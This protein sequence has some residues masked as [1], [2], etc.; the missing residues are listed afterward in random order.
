MNFYSLI[1][2]VCFSFTLFTWVKCG[3]NKPDSPPAI[4]TPLLDLA[5]DTAQTRTGYGRSLK[6]TY[7]DMTSFS[8]YAESFERK[9]YLGNTWLD[10]KN[11]FPDFESPA[12]QNRQLDSIVFFGKLVAN[13]PLMLQ[14]KLEDIFHN[15]AT[16]QTLVQP[17]QQWQR[18]AFALDDFTGNFDP[19]HAKFIGFVF[20]DGLGQ[21]AGTSGSF[22]LDDLYFVESCFQKPTFAHEADMFDYLNEVAFRHFWMAVEPNSKFALDRHVWDDLISVDVIGFSLSACVIAHKEGWVEPAKVEDRVEHVLT[23][24][25]DSCAHATAP[26]MVASQPLDF[27]T[28]RGVW[29]HFLDHQTLA[30]KDKRTEFSLFTTALLLAGVVTAGEYFHWNPNIVAKADALYRMT[31]W[32]FLLRQDGL[33]NYDWKPETGFSPY[34]SDWFSEEPDLAFLLG[35]SSPEPA[36]KLP[37]NPFFLAGYRKPLCFDGTYIYSASGSN[38]TYWFLQM[39]ARYG[40]A[41]GRFQ[42]AKKA[43]L[44]DLAFCQ[45]EYAALGYDP[46]IFGT[47]A[48][49][50]TDSAG[51]AI[52]GT[53]TV[54]ISNYHA[55][56]YCCKFDPFNDGNGTVAPYGSGSAALFLPQQV[57]ALWSYFYNDLDQ[58]FWNEYASRF[59][60]PI[61]GMP[62]AFHL[63]P[64]AASDS[65]VNGLGFRGPWLSVPRFGIDVGPMLMNLDSYLSEAAGEPSVRDYFSGC[66]HIAANLAQFAEIP[67]TG[68]LSPSISI[69]AQASSVCEG[70]AIGLTATAENGGEAPVFQWF[71]N[72]VL[73]QRGND[74]TFLLQ[75]TAGSYLIFCSMI[76]SASCIEGAAAASNVDADGV[77]PAR[78]LVGIQQPRVCG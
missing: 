54:F 43:L 23:W 60:S 37:E 75:K 64:D 46:L 29:A 70:G 8:I 78:S 77:V 45:N 59:W 62:D 42:N 61:F 10:L 73:A 2:S 31:D 56:G 1:L 63:D 3:G 14:L 16:I 4:V 27:A 36:H 11:L 24:L 35:I 51:V 44:A 6:I 28:V 52:E 66:P 17:S 71:V 32:N 13:Q 76:S 9:W 50:G 5:Y 34:Y 15:G 57:E 39:Y 67:P 55:Y 33:M 58:L 7:K 41:T 21:N 18:F 25:L 53:D 19:T 30:R 49:E 38:F 12:F 40:E 72:G 47:T 22:F 68:T 74:P 26:S 48:C 20:A 69:S 65:P